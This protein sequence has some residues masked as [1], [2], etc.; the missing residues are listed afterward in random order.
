M[1]PARPRPI[2]DLQ[3]EP[4]WQGACRKVLL[5]QYCEPCSERVHPSRPCCPNCLN[6][7]LG[8]VEVSGA[9]TVISYCIVAQSFVTGVTAPYVAVRVALADAPTV[10]LVANLVGPTRFDAAIDAPVHVVFEEID[11]DL[12]LP[13]FEL[14]AGVA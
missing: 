12:V 1:T 14:G 11:A 7:E 9:G 5:V 13:Q 3:T 2:P 8:W 4:Y 10:E 6:T